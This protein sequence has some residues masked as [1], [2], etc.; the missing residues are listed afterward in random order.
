M[1]APSLT[2]R[3]VLAGAGS[4][5]V[6][7][8]ISR[9]LA[10][11]GEVQATGGP[12]PAPKLP[13]SLADAPQ[14]D[15]WI[16]IDADGR[17]TVFTGKAELGQGLRT[18]ILQIAA[19]ELEVD[20]GG[21]TLVTADT[22]MT[23]NEGYTAGSQSMQNSGTAIRHAAAQVREILIA[24]AARRLGVP[25]DGLSAADG[26]VRAADGRAL[27]YGELV[28]DVILH[29]EAQAQSR[30]KDSGA[31]RHMGRSMARVD[32]PAKVTG[33]AAYVQDLRL[34]GTVHARVVRPPSPAARLMEL[35]PAAVEAMPGVVRVVRDGSFLAVVAEREWQAVKAMRALALAARWS[36]TPSLPR[37]AELYPTLQKM[38]S[39]NGIVVEEGAAPTG[40]RVL[41]ATYTR[42]YQMHGSIGPSCAVALA[43]GEGL[44]VWS[45]TQG[46]F[47]D[48]IAIAAM[49]K[50]PRE[51]LRVIHMEGAGCYG[52]NGADDAAA[53]AALIARALPG[54]PVRVQWTRE[55]EHAFEPY[56][57]AMIGR[58]RATLGDDGRIQGWDY[59]VWTNTHSTRPGPAGALLAAR[60]LASPFPEQEPKLQIAPAGNGDR[61]AVPLYAFPH[62]RVVWHFI[63]DMPLRVSALR[64]LGAYLNVFALESFMDELA[65][66]AGAD[67]VEFRLRHLADPRA[68]DVVNLA[69][70]RFGWKPGVKLP[71][72]RGRGFAFARYK[73]SAG[74]CALAVEVEVERES[75][76]TRVVR[77]VAAADSGEVVNPDGI[78][79][80]IEGGILQAMSWTL[81]E[82][83]TFDETR[84]TSVD[85]ASYPILRFDAVPDTIETHIIP[86]PGQP[87][88]GTGEVSQGPTP[89]AIA[90]AIADATGQR[91]RD[92]PFT[93]ETVKA[94]I[95][96]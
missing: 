73:N 93:R 40:G 96:V 67:P 68:R 14:L 35:D 71:N 32:I 52:H 58:L 75:G 9:A 5:V 63:K 51:R 22:A 4:L 27:R 28:A 76:R 8:S 18:A 85:W 15:A 53:D 21:I 78:R 10:Q 77:A 41:E 48:R 24:E 26:T 89:A 90:N 42:P 66:A 50:M 64:A 46:V 47:P 3:S 65:A 36:E 92:L 31:F 33:G 25:G 88:L 62:K 55:Q 30:L 59:G 86:R 44:T 79:S 91:L 49:L 60:H 72:G 61:N 84:V 29:V 45:H 1:T 80:Q 13:G 87:F 94:A 34:P 38:V 39:E 6:A 23:P 69:A 20:P 57:P 56:G 17:V 16:R 82:S 2:R 83:V 43:E 54:R 12:K 11:Q 70:E 81:Y 74:Y 37:Q 7:F 19:E 95:G